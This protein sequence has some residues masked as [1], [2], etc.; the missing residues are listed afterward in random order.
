[1][2]HLRDPGLDADTA[3]GLRGYQAKVDSAATYAEQVDAGKCLFGLY[4]SPTNP[5]FR[6]VRKR[7]AVMC[8]GARRCG[9]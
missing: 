6:M 2:L 1:M 8:S 5:V 3:R 9:Y 7:L 4:S